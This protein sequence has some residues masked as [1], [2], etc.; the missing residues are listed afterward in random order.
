LSQVRKGETEVQLVIQPI[1]GKVGIRARPPWSVSYLIIYLK[2]TPDSCALQAQGR[3][4]PTIPWHWHW[5]RADTEEILRK[6]SD[7]MR[8]T[9]WGAHGG[10]SMSTAIPCSKAKSLSGTPFLHL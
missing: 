6:C 10:P 3:L 7:F 8:N 9:S 2:G 5:L 4:V 1:Y